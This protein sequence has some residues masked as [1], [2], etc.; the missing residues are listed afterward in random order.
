MVHALI[1]AIGLF[2]YMKY[3]HFHALLQ[4]VFLIILIACMHRRRSVL[5]DWNV[6]TAKIIWML[7]CLLP[8]HWLWRN[9]KSLD[10]LTMP[11]CFPVSSPT[12]NTCAGQLMPL[13]EPWMMVLDMSLIGMGADITLK[14]LQLQAIAILTVMTRVCVCVW[15]GKRSH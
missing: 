4:C 10:W 2:D 6:F 15:K 9:W 14:V 5:V 8:V 1:K 11:H 12:W 7:C 3:R 13:E